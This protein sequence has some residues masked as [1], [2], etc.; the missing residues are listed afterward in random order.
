MFRFAQDGRVRWPVT[1]EQLQDDGSTAAQTF[2]VVYRVMTREELRTRD[3]AMTDFMRQVRALMPADGAADTDEQAEQRRELTD[4][5]LQA[6]DALLT[7]RVLGWF[8]IADQDGKPIPFSATALAA[9]LR[10]ELLRDTLLQGL[11]D[12]SSGAHSK[13]SRPGL[14]GLPAPAQ[15]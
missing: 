11:V 15:A 9:F 14:A 4:R 8:D 3:N 6:D 12:A 2:A 7:D 10:N 1:I 5:R 13:N